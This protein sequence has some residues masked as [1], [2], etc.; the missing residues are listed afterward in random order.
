[1]HPDPS[2]HRL[3]PIQRKRKKKTRVLKQRGEE[4]SSDLEH[5]VQ[6]RELHQRPLPKLN[7]SPSAVK[8]KRNKNF[9][10]DDEM[11]HE[12][13]CRPNVPKLDLSSIATP[14]QM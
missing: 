11:L 6:I 10:Q 2:A 3:P 5:S 4:T 1:M 9:D 7:A 13:E 14:R 8:S 12:V